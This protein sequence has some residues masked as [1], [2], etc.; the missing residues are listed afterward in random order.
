MRNLIIIFLAFV[1]NLAFAQSNSA[2]TSYK[3]LQANGTEAQYIRL[4][5][6][7][8]AKENLKSKAV[9][10]VLTD[11]AV[12]YESFFSEEELQKM[13]DFYASDSGQ[14]L[15]ND[16]RNMTPTDSENFKDYITSPVG[17]KYNTVIDDLNSKE[18][19]IQQDWLQTLN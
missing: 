4:Y 12:A 10:K 11:I 13:L 17:E 5:E 2:K 14:Q 3:L 18:F 16:R 8:N 7:N 15:V 1:G 6:W 19:S 9:E